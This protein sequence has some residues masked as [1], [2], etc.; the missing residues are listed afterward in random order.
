MLRVL[1]VLVLAGAVLL[2]PSAILA[3]EIACVASDAATAMM[4]MDDASMPMGGEMH[5]CHHQTEEPGNGPMA[6]AV[7]PCTHIDGLATASAERTVAAALPPVTTLVR[8]LVGEAVSGHA[9]WR[10]PA[11]PPDRSPRLTP[12]R[13]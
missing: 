1:G 9:A 6:G 10:T 3:C 13:I 2:A 8:P 11:R 12:L 5:G 4:Q 7:H